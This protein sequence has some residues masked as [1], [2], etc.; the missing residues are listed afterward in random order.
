MHHDDHNNEFERGLAFDLS[1]LLQRRS[2][3]K[4]LA[5]T[6]LLA[7]VGC[8]SDDTSSSSATTA[9]SGATTG[10]T[11]TAGTTAP[12]GTTA[13]TAATADTAAT[14]T[15]CDVIPQET[16][17]PFPGDGTNG[18]NL[19]T[20]SGVVRQDIRTSIGSASGTAEGVTLTVQLTLLD[21]ANGC[22]PLSG[23][24][25]Y[26]WHATADGR[27]SMYS[28]GVTDENFLRGVQESAADGTLSFT[29]VYP[30]CYDG[31]WPH[32]H[33]EVYSDLAS[34]TNGGNAIATSQLAFP[35]ETCEVVYAADGYSASVGN[36]ARVSLEGDNVFS[37]DGA[38]HQL[39]TMSGDNA[40]GWNAQLI[41][42]V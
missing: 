10:T 13:A 23:A 1:T 2:M 14:A 5:G 15:S 28:D 12:S 19:L 31:R 9:P 18:P 36:L 6:G 16:G 8:S 22:S 20:E 26:L 38:V 39:A 25:V 11:A 42:T 35:R 33:F 24:A 41:V 21:S 17:G 37:D 40:A 27:Y 30:G 7:L 29:T 34:A 3:L 32:I 4:L